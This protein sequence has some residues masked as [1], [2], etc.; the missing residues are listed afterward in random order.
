MSDRYRIVFAVL[1][2]WLVL[3]GS[4]AYACTR[5]VYQG[6]EQT[7]ITARSM[8]WRD[9]IPADL[10]LFPVGWSG[11]AWWAITPCAGPPATAVLLPAHLA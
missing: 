4:A 2:G 10:W 7:I 8:D 1:L 6:P 11:R 3:V 9:E 5:V